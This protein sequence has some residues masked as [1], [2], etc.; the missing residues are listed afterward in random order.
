MTS[1]LQNYDHIFKDKPAFTPFSLINLISNLMTPTKLN[2]SS[3]PPIDDILAK[4]NNKSFFSSLDFSSGYWQIPLDPSVRQYTSFLYDGRSY[5]FCVVTFVLNISNAAFGKELEAAL[6]NYTIPCPSLND[7]HTYETLFIRKTKT[8]VHWSLY[9]PNHLVKQI[10]LLFHYYYAHTG[11][12]KTAHALKNICYFYSFNKTVR[13]IVQTCELC[14]KCKPKTTRI[15]G[16]LQPILSNKPLDKLLVDSYGPL[17]TG[18]FQFSYIFVIVDNFT[19]YFP[20]YG[21][22]KNIVSNHG[23][24]FISIYWQTSLKEYNIQ[25]S[26]TSVYHPQSNPAERFTRELGR[27]FRTYCHKQHSLWPQYVLYI[28][29]TLNNIR[30]ES[31]HHT[32]SALFLQNT[33]EVQLSKSEYRKKYQRERLNPTFFKINHLDLVRT[34][35]L[36]NKIDKKISKFFLLYDG[37]LKVKS[38]LVH[39]DDDTPQGTHNVSQL[40]PYISPTM[41]HII[42]PDNKGNPISILS[43]SC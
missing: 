2:H 22:P 6:N 15:A 23:R 42:L 25:V 12:L 31:T 24:Q 19:H 13:C 36:S 10:V 28:E 4:F 41:Y 9:F 34:H 16:P 21:I 39:P 8:D 29:W 14:Q 37:P 3:P 43:T 5:Q 33:Q 27:M 35:K 1:L 11:P 26:H 18:V 20:N 17:P 32:P 40:K 38:E 30:H 7:I